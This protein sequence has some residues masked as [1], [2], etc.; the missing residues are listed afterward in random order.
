MPGFSRIGRDV[1][2]CMESRK[3]YKAT[4]DPQIY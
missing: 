4:L 2:K 3:N 1:I